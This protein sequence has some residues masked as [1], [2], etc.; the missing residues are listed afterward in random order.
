LLSAEPWRGCIGASGFAPSSDPRAGLAQR[1]RRVGPMGLSPRLGAA[2]RKP[3]RIDYMLPT[4]LSLAAR[5]AL[6][7]DAVR[8]RALAQGLLRFPASGGPATFD[9]YDD[10]GATLAELVRACR[11]SPVVTRRRNAPVTETL[12]RTLRAWCVCPWRGALARGV[13]PGVAALRTVPSPRPRTV[14]DSV[15]AI[16]F[17]RRVVVFGV[18]SWRRTQRRVRGL[19]VST[20]AAG[21]RVVRSEL[22]G[23]GL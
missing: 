2:D 21:V 12:V 9:R 1:R 13:L 14:R 8:T 6:E 4:L 11:L 22:P 16:I 23:G 20:D 15:R 5:R 3:W 7:V 18:M 17:L 10:T 19:D